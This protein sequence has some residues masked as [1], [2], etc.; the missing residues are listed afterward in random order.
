[1]LAVDIKNFSG[2]RGVDHEGLTAAIPGIL[3][4]ALRRGGL[5][6]LTEAHRFDQ[7]SGDGWLRGFDPTV[8][9]FL[10]NPFLS[11]L[12]D[13]LADRNHRGVPGHGTTQPMR[14]R[15][16]I[17]VG[18]VTDSGR[19]LAW[20]GSGTARVATHRLLDAAPVR[21]LLERSDPSATHIA[22]IVSAR[23]YEDAVVTGY[24]AMPESLF[25]RVPVE[26]KTYND[27]GYLHVPRVSGRLLAEGFGTGS[28]EPAA[29]PPGDRGNGRKGP[30]GSGGKKRGQGRSAGPRNVR[31]AGVGDVGRAT[32]V[33]GGNVEGQ[34]ASGPHFAGPV[35]T[36]LSGSTAR[37]I[38]SG[39]ITSGESR[40]DG[41]AG[42]PEPDGAAG[43]HDTE[44]T[45]GGTRPAGGGN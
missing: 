24:A 7:P 20:D 5:G 1:M 25:H 32:N 8:T 16:S 35:G 10:I 2:H 37:D 22:V 13:E 18:P 34:F 6:H 29:P 31:V 9:P 4:E 30:V 33:I 12:E 39:D 27:I 42:R 11:G 36:Y 23:A 26:V 44:D 40:A 45:G 14:M 43:V 15:V 28:D 3:D 38:T 21:A 41:R 19:N 17:H